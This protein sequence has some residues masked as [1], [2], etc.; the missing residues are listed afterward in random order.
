MQSA[1]PL[2][3]LVGTVSMTIAR[4]RFGLPALA[5][6]GAVWGGCSGAPEERAA[7]YTH[8][9]SVSEG[10]APAEDA[11]PP[12]E[13]PPCEEGAQRECIVRRRQGN[14]VVSCWT[15]TQ[16]CVDGEW[17]ECF[18]PEQSRSPARKGSAG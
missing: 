1:S 5:L 4:H 3:H 16:F 6:L 12:F 9:S 8:A 14:G 18:E 10:G 11:H 13:R 2:P 15:G 17:S 7:P